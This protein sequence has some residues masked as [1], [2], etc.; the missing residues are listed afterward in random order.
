MTLSAGV[1]EAIAFRS[2]PSVNGI[3]PIA[4]LSAAMFSD[5]SGPPDE[6]IDVAR[7][8]EIHKRCEQGA[9]STSWLDEAL[10]LFAAATRVLWE[11]IN[12]VF[13]QDQ[14]QSMEEL[15]EYIE[16]KGPLSKFVT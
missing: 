1:L 8:Y 4:G 7:A 12:L 14:I 3:A 5:A 2:R 6:Y 13:V 10:T 11:S 15:H 9:S 16:R